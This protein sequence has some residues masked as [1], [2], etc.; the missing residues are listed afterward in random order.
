[1][2]LA[3][4]GLALALAAC[5]RAP[6]PKPDARY[7]LGEPYSLRGL[8]SY[9]KEE[10]GRVETGLA[11]VLPD[12]RA[13]RR[14]AN[15]EIFDPDRLV[16]AHRTLQLPAI[17]TVW[18]LE[19]G[20]ELR[21]RVNDRGP[22]QPGR[23]IGL[24]ARAAALLGIPPG[25]AAQVR[26]AV[27]DAPSRALARAL[28]STERLGPQVEAVQVGTVERESLPPPPGA[29]QAERV[30]EAPRGPAV[31]TLAAGSRDLPP[32]PLPEQVVQRAAMPG[33]LYVEA[34]SFFRRD[35]ALRQASR[36]GARVEPFG[37]GRTPQWRVRLG[38]FRDVA[39][40][41]RAVAAVLSAGLPEVKLLVE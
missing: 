30:R 15:G 18:N 37:E 35:L 7:M 26:V 21:L 33:H 16:G 39:A 36:I 2:R 10:F 31:A 40:A 41:D 8:W 25:G 28:P 32:D 23:V 6:A 17:V 13:G 14:T 3:A 12:R 34:G 38:P 11:A 29:R 20:R 1:M 22:A 27:E 9:P 19:T 4:L 24:S 5:E